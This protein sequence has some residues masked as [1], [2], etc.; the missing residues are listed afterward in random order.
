MKTATTPREF[1]FPYTVSPAEKSALI[2]QASGSERSL[3]TRRE[4]AESHGGAKEQYAQW[5]CFMWV[6]ENA[7]SSR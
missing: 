3:E 5:A 1:F 7:G 4:M 2:G 6:P